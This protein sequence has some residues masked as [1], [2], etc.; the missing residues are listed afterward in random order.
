MK[1]LFRLAV[2][3]LVRNMRRTVLTTTVIIAGIGVLI[4]G[5]GFV[6][7]VCRMGTTHHPGIC[8]HYGFN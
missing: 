1:L 2:R 5:E 8:G 7:G 6:S 3:N 4:L